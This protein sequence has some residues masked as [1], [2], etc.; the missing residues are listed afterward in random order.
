MP[1]GTYTNSNNTITV[2]DSDSYELLY[3]EFVHA[4]QDDLNISSTDFAIGNSN[5]EYEAYIMGLFIKDM[6]AVKD[7]KILKLYFDSEGLV[8]L[9]IKATIDI[10]KKDSFLDV[11]SFSDAI[12]PYYESSFLP[13]YSTPGEFYIE[14]LSSKYNDPNWQWNWEKYQ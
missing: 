2:T 11:S 8:A 3:H 9:D 7:E 12:N 1:H 4:V 10:L 6:Y 14:K 13:H 5:L